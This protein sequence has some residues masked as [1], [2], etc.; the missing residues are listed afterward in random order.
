MRRFGHPSRRR[1]EVWLEQGAPDLDDHIAG[2]D[3]CASRLEELGAP[4]GPLG[5]ALRAVLEPP[6]DLQPRLR[7]GIATKLQVRED[8]RLLAEMFSIPAQTLRALGPP[9]DTEPPGDGRG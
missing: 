1:L 5:D 8:L 9:P 6:A 2:C 3:R 4:S 7:S